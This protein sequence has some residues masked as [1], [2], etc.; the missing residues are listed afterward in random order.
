MKTL[1]ILSQK[2]GCGKTT[3]AVHLLAYA[4]T[5]G[6]SAGL[7][8]LDPQESALDW[9]MSREPVDRFVAGNKLTALPVG[10]R[11]VDT[12]PSSDA[13]AALAAGAADFILIPT[14][15]ARFDLNAVE[16][17]LEICRY[18][19]K[20]HAVILNAVPHNN[21]TGQEAEAAMRDAGVPLVPLMI[22]NRVAFSHA[23][24]NGGAVHEFEPDGK[25]AAEIRQL[26]AWI[27]GRMDL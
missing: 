16:S 15:A 2:G 25:A 12:P 21:R 4:A 6:L 7:V 19:R 26:F 14:R 20:P 22:I 8:D 5:Q 1:T 3:I 13:K 24:I 10:L 18:A 11:I 27:K 9:N 17:T 23:V